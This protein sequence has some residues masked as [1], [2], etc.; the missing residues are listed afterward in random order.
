M[1]KKQFRKTKLKIMKRKQILEKRLVQTWSR[2]K[3]YNKFYERLPV[4]K[5][6]NF[7]KTTQDW[8]PSFPHELDEK[9]TPRYVISKKLVKFCEYLKD[10]FC[11]D[12]NIL[13]DIRYE[14]DSNSGTCFNQISSDGYQRIMVGARNGLRA[15][16]LIHEFLHASGLDHEYEIN[17]YSDYRSTC[18]LDTYSPLI[19]KDIFG[20]KEV[21]L[22]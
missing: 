13:L 3:R 7:D 6:F 11:I 8:N 20:K 19:V 17:G 4:I 15:T 10:L 16:T 9:L 21:L 12:T 2:T 18:T 1:T 14:K 22:T 5:N